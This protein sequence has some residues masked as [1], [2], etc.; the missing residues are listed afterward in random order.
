MPTGLF[1]HAKGGLVAIAYTANELL[2]WCFE[3]NT[4]GIHANVL[5]LLNF[6]ALLAYLSCV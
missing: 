2:L 1:V 4:F 6:L 3:H 5:A